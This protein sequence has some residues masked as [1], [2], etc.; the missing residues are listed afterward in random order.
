MCSCWTLSG[1][2]YE[3]KVVGRVVAGRCQVEYMSV[4]L[5]DV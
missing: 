1:R 4:R 5:L 2:V 3:W